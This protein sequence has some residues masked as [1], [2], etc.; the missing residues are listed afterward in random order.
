M[1]KALFRLKDVFDPFFKSQF[2]DWRRL[3]RYF[4]IDKM[5]PK[6]IL[7]N[8]GDKEYFFRFILDGA[9][10]MQVKQGRREVCFDL[11]FENDFLTD[12]ESLNRDKLTDIQIQTFEPVSALLI[13][14]ANLFR[15]Y[16]ASDFGTQLR[17]ALAEHQNQR[18]HK[19]NIGY[20]GKTTSER[21]KKLLEDRPEW[22]LRTP[23]HFIASFLGVSPENL[24]RVRR[25]LRRT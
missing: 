24:S 18:N 13:N 14:R 16:Q 11:C 4:V 23:Q 25:K 2:S 1:E 10:A 3:E 17:R 6:T 12:F 9:A 21:Y 19:N 15:I 22:L 7:K 5:K 8:A 20:L